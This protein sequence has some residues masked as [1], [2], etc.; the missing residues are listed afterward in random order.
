MDAA[1]AQVLEQAADYIEENGWWRGPRLGEVNY[2]TVRYREDAQCATFAIDRI[3]HTIESVAIA[4]LYKYLEL[5]PPNQLS[6]S[7]KMRVAV[8]KWN[9]S[10]DSGEPVVAAMRACAKQLKGE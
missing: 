9:D 5:G 2:S 10:H 7:F 6:F 1:T 8:Q 4:E 3:T